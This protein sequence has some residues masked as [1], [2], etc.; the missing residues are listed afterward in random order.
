METQYSQERAEWLF[1]WRNYQKTF[2]ATVEQH[3]DNL[4]VLP[5][6]DVDG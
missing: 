1:Y 2:Q 6:N 4:P 5:K 3:W